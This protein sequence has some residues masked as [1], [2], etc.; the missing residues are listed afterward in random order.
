MASLQSGWGGALYRVAVLESAAGR[1]TSEMQARFMG[2]TPLLLTR[3]EHFGAFSGTYDLFVAVEG[4]AEEEIPDLTARVLLVPG[5]IPQKTMA[6]ISSGWVVSYGL[7]GK[8]S[9]T[10][11]SLEP[12]F[13]V[14]ALQRELVTLEGKVVEQQEIPL[15][16]SQSLDS[17]GLMAV[18]GSLLVLGKKPE[19]IARH[20]EE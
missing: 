11:S 5:S 16:F 4:G 10:L 6:G 13:A 8:D 15:S 20:L 7:S 18:Y 12:G 19:A 17:Q 1:V 9:I 3:G 14:L 2:C